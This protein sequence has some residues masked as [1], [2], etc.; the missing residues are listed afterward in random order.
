MSFTIYYVNIFA[1]VIH[2]SFQK[3]INLKNTP[4]H[5]AHP[6]HSIQMTGKKCAGVC[7]RCAGV[8]ELM[9]NGGRSETLAHIA[10]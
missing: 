7:A 2:F 6:A 3:F 9:K 1:T 10:K 8:S 4:A 5:L